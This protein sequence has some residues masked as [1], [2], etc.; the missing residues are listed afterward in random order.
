MNKPV[1]SMGELCARVSIDYN[2]NTWAAINGLLVGYKAICAHYANGCVTLA[3]IKAHLPRDLGVQFVENMEPASLSFIRQV[4]MVIHGED[5]TPEKHW[6]ADVHACVAHIGRTIDDVQ[7]VEEWKVALARF[8]GNV[9]A[10]VEA[11]WRH[12]LE[13]TTANENALRRFKKTVESADRTITLRN[14]Y[15]YHGAVDIFEAYDRQVEYKLFEYHMKQR[16]IID[17]LNWH[18]HQPHTPDEHAAH[19]KQA[20]AELSKEI[21]QLRDVLMGIFNEI[22]AKD[23]LR[24]YEEYPLI[25]SVRDLLPIY[26]KIKKATA[27]NHQADFADRDLVAILYRNAAYCHIETVEYRGVK[28]E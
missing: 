25:P 16:A 19:K 8:E 1:V 3:D 23:A 12:F 24:L 26:R 14:L 4:L 6:L 10:V 22:A 21:R 11:H 5:V 18:L 15:R 13:R 2:N 7:D 27:D 20:W 17:L 28:Y 9:Y